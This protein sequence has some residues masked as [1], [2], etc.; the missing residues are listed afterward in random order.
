M[1]PVT[2]GHPPAS[3]I[4]AFHASCSC[5]LLASGSSMICTDTVSHGLVSI[6]KGAGSCLCLAFGSPGVCAD[7]VGAG[8]GLPP[9]AA[10]PAALASRPAGVASLPTEKAAAVHGSPAPPGA[11]QRAPILL[12]FTECTRPAG[13]ASAWVARLTAICTAERGTQ[14]SFALQLHAQ[15]PAACSR[16]AFKVQ[17]LCRHG[18]A[19]ALQGQRHAS[20]NQQ[21]CNASFRALAR[22]EMPR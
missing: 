21:H 14:G 4:H 22:R 15:E 12:T 20:A 19:A 8:H 10:R 16:R 11:E 2:M 9:V 6:N 5:S 17:L 7:S 1:P 18:P 3:C 13:S